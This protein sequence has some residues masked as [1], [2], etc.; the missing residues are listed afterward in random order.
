[1]NH[2]QGD[3]KAGINSVKTYK[4]LYE[5]MLSPE[6]V[7]KCA[8][9]AA[10]GKIRRKEVVSAFVHFDNTYD[11][12]IACANNP[13]YVPCEDN[14]HEIIDGANHKEREIEKPKFVP[15]Q[16]LHHMIVEPFKPVLMEGLYEQTYGCLPPTIKEGKDGKR[17]VKKY[18]PHAAIRQLVKWAQIGKKVYI[19]EADV[20]H[21]YGSV[22]IPTLVGQLRRVVKDKEWIR[23][24]CQF[25]HYKENDPE[26]AEMYGLILGHY[27]S[28][29][30]FNFYLKAFDHF[31]AKLQGVKYLR[32][33]DNF[34]L[35]GT[36]KR[37]IHRALNAMRK[38]L[39][40]KLRLTLNG[41]TQVYRFEHG[42]G[43][44]DKKGKEITQGRQI[45]AL[46][47]V[48]HFNRETLRK[49]ILMRMRRKA[50][51]IGRKG[52]G[53]TWHDGSS[54]LARLAWVKCTDTHKYYEDHIKPLIHNKRLKAKVRLHSKAIQ[55]IIKER[56]RIIYDGLE[57]S[58]RLSEIEAERI[59][60][61]IERNRRIPAAQYRAH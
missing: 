8:L 56:R 17:Y 45:N 38:Y 24:T 23:L 3:K 2:R 25:L 32:F 6:M 10:D 20:K 49:S 26:S 53:T 48:I 5:S 37:K 36:N 34:Y 35:V 11:H 51:R 42:M 50:I 22:H 9:D 31:A 13:D 1:M 29:W 41:S 30:L 21:A 12:V 39:K 16:I 14:T 54:M 28:P 15:E 18:G 57:R 7:A 4:H 59:R 43:K 27:T 44:F 47:A 40:E 61:Y 33:A 19:A 55:S 60:P 52:A 46:G 58:T